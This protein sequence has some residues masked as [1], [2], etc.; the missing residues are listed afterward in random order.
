MQ[1][2]EYMVLNRQGGSWTDDRFDGRTPAEKLTELGNEG[3]ELVSVGY[4]GAGYNFYLKR[5]IEQKAKG[6]PRKPR[7]KSK[8]DDTPAENPE[9]MENSI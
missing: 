4:D 2:W 5:P 3:W 1:K 6:A 9:S 8:A 7:A